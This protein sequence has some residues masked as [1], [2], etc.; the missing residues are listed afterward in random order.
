MIE[1]ILESMQKRAASN[2]V[3]KALKVH[4]RD[5]NN[6]ECTLC[7]KHVYSVMLTSPNQSEG[8]QVCGNCMTAWNASQKKA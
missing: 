4:F 6:P 3:R 8:L 5:A 7:K 2:R 1:K